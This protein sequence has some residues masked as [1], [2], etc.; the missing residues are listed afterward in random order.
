MVQD[1]FERTMQ[2]DRFFYSHVKE[3]GDDLN[4]VGF[5]KEAREIIAARSMSGV[6]CDTTEITKVPQNVF[7]LKS[8]I[9]DCENTANINS[10]H[11]LELMKFI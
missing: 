11:V 3:L 5:T 2:G 6:I 7:S 8:K 1:Q 10:E 9:I 4:G